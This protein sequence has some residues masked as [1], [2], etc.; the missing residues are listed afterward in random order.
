MENVRACLQKM[1]SD[2]INGEIG[3]DEARELDHLLGNL[4]K[5]LLS[6]FPGELRLPT[7]RNFHCY[8]CK[9]RGVSKHAAIRTMCLQCGENEIEREAL[10][11]DLTGKIAVVTGGRVKIGFY[12]A[13]RLL[14][15]NCSV[16][17]TTR[18]VEDCI[19]RYQKEPDYEEL[20]DRLDIRQLDLMDF[21]AISAFIAAISQEYPR[22]DFLILNAAQTLARPAEFYSREISLAPQATIPSLEFS[23]PRFLEGE[24][25][26]ENKEE[27]KDEVFPRDQRDEHDQQVDLRPVN[28]WVLKAEEVPLPELVKVGL[29]N[30]TAP[31]ALMVGLKPMM[32]KHKTTAYIIAVSSMEG[33]F[34]YKAKDEHHVHTNMAKA[35]L[36]MIV[37][38]VG[39][40]WRR[41]HNIHVVAVDTGW[42]TQMRPLSNIPSPIDCKAGACRIVDPIFREEKGS[43]IFLKDFVQHSW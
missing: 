5:K 20:K 23:A 41:D 2:V 17:V 40:A 37:K 8:V 21:P 33:C 26:G 25:V 18:F 32:G 9:R 35:S 10:T 7:N 28:S 6:R 12:T 27:E 36:N 43:G 24:G 15:A 22:L 16:I 34:S 13:L 42:N 3:S 31:F 1:A 30:S 38:T 29:I 14:R 4:H 11:R 19:T 39:K